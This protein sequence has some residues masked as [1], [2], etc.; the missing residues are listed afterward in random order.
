M[1]GSSRKYGRAGVHNSDYDEEDYVSGKGVAPAGVH[2]SDE[3]EDSFDMPNLEE[4]TVMEPTN[5]NEDDD[6]QVCAEELARTS[7][8]TSDREKYKRAKK[9][10][11]RR[12]D[13]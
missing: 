2:N 5:N 10:G 8:T 6:K 12:E 7:P 9:G 11:W 13:W 4:R 1:I 3:D